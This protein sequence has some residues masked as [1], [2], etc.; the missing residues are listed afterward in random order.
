VIRING[1]ARPTTCPNSNSCATPINPSDVAAAATLTLQIE[2]P[3]GTLSNPVP[4]VVAPLPSSPSALHL[5]SA[6]ASTKSIQL[7]AAE[8]T[9]AASSSPINVN[10]IGM[11]ADN[12]CTIGAA[13][14]TVTRPASGTSAL[15]I[16]LQGDGLDPTLTYSFGGPAAAP[17]GTDIPVTASAVPGLLPNM[18]QLNLELSS[19]ASPGLRTL[20]I[21][22]LNGD[23]ATATGML[24]V[25]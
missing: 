17:N 21:S 8:P 13:P 1:A 2:N 4:F 24:E 14:I 22:T 16:C 10:F 12:N 11:L 7:T 3:D 15:S 18:V 6:Q 9:T 23:R 20:F 25:Q 5:S 19:G